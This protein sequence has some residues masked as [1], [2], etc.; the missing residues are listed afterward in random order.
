MDPTIQYQWR[1]IG[2][3]NKNL[4]LSDQWE[5]DDIRLEP[6]RTDNYEGIKVTVSHITYDENRQKAR[7]E[8]IAELDEFLKT[9]SF[10][11]K[12]RIK[13]TEEK[14]ALVNEEEISRQRENKTGA[15]YLMCNPLVVDQTDSNILDA[16]IR[17]NETI[18]KNPS[19][20]SLKKCRDWYVSSLE[21][22]DP[23]DKFLSIW[24]AFN[25]MY[26]LYNALNGYKYKDEYDDHSKAIYIKELL[27]SESIMSQIINL[28]KLI[29][30]LN[31]YDISRTTK[32]E[33]IMYNMNLQ[34]KY[35]EKNYKEAFENLL[36][37]LYKIRC[38]LF[39]G[40][41]GRDDFRQKRL[42]TRCYGVLQVLV[43]EAFSAYIRQTAR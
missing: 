6:F 33:T 29:E 20:D 12:Y 17:L 4:L 21:H 1:L 3:L 24:I 11:Y 8:A 30:L 5:H 36:E 41:K 38:N 2:R 18:R 19:R 9:W 23:T 34:E 40:V 32:K 27:D 15:V 28:P 13:L 43:K 7:E 42:L 25:I 37:C 16:T 26:N 10:N 35:K 22:Q 31:Q 39:H 14:L